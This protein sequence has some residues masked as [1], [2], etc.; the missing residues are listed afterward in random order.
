MDIKNFADQ[1][2]LH[3]ASREG[4]PRSIECLV[5]YGADVG[6]TDQQGNTPLHY[7]LAK[8]NV[9]PLSDWTLHLNEVTRMV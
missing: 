1:S 3:V 4:Y 8:K 2:P 5:G 7:I 9:K 6:V